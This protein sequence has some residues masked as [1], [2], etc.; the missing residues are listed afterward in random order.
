[1]LQEK[2]LVDMRVVKATGRER[3]A[4]M[5]FDEADNIV[6]D[7]S[8]GRCWVQKVTVKEHD[9]NSATCELAD[10]QKFRFVGQ[11]SGI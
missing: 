7:M 10:T 9:A 1:M 8:N 5:A 6:K 3:F 2:G 4:E 11:Q